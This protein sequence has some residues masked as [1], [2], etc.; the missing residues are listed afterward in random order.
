MQNHAAKRKLAPKFQETFGVPLS[1]YF[2]NILGFDIVAFDE[3][4]IK[5]GDSKSMEETVRL[6]YSQEAVDL[7]W[8]LL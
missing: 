7:I 3:D 2:D 6:K 4:V 1:T 8:Q 5:S